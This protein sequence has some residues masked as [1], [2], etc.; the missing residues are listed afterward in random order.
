MR[1]NLVNGNTT[2][3]MTEMIAAHARHVA[4]PGTRIDARTPTMGPSS[5][6]G[7]Y[8]GALAVPGILAAI[9]AGERSGCDAHIIACFDD[10]GVDAARALATAPVIGIAEAAVLTA[11]LVSTRFSVITDLAVSIA[12]LE[13]LIRL[14]GAEARLRRIR[15]IDMPVLELASGAV[16]VV[17]LLRPEIT[18]AIEMDRADAVILGCASMCTAAATLRERLDVPVVEGVGAAVKLAEGLATLGLKTGKT[19]GYA[20]PPRKAYAGLLAPFTLPGPLP[21]AE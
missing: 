4:A 6:E 20:S 2:A 11:G 3:A 18:R 19:G 15:C 16:D 10:P 8:D 17:D 1:L 7:F 13:R 14:C 9:D 21:G 5:I 12:P